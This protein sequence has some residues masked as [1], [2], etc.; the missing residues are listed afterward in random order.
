[1]AILE[2]E[3]TG[4][5]S[6]T[7]RIPTDGAPLTA[8]G[9]SLWRSRGSFELDGQAF[10]ID[11]SGFFLQ[12]AALKRGGTTI[13]RAEKPSILQ[14]RYLITSAG[15]RM[16]LESRSWSG[17][18][19]VL[20]LGGKEV[21]WVRREGMTGRKVLLDFPEEV[22]MALRVFL[23]YLVLAQAKRESAAAGGG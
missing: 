3:P 16:T 10:S 14:R 8:L 15:H 1:M 12:N 6:W 2:A 13:A 18:K 17:R 4:W 19:Y 9:I 11:P 22:P 5:G 21:G 7:A 20:L 23:L